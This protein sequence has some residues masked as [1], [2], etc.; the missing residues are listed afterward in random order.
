MTA[1][2]SFALHRARSVEEATGLLA[3]LGDDAVIYSGGTELLLLMKLG[4]AT[5]GHLVD[6]K[7]IDEL[8]GIG[9]VDGW[10]RIGGA[11]THR[12]IERSPLVA[13]GWPALIAME[14]RVANIRVR[15]TGTLGGNLAFA[16]PHSDPATFLIA[17]D[18]RLILGLGT[19][20]RTV[21]ITEFVRGP[22]ET[23]LRPSELLVAIEVPPLPG[24]AAMAH[25]RFAFHE[26]PAATVSCLARV[27]EGLMVEARISVGSVGITP[28]R[29]GEAESLLSGTP[30]ADLPAGVLEAAGCA[31]ADAA[32]PMTDANGS[33]TYKRNL[34]RVLVGRCIREASEAALLRA[35]AA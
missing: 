14:R 1:L 15:S 23:A 31:A 12:I 4:F 21:P 18:A 6:V 8:A 9:M 33:S 25:L 26:R 32:D 27:R 29:A 30:A 20:R 17:A 28:V 10:L 13:A 2:A 16:D 35:P 34:V 3:E 22:Y 5:Y 11:V 24:D 7:P 19:A